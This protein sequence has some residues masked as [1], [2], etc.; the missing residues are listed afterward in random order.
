MAV[1]EPVRH[2]GEPRSQHDG[3][4]P[5]CGAICNDGAGRRIQKRDVYPGAVVV[6]AAV[7]VADGTVHVVS[8]G[9]DG[10]DSES[11][12]ARARRRGGGGRG[13]VEG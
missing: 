4:H 12:C 10:A 8:G 1:P 13:V 6:A 5:R 9:D 3:P 7:G 11:E 2:D